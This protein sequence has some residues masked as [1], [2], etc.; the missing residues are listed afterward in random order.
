M[1]KVIQFLVILL[2]DLLLKEFLIFL[3]IKVNLLRNV[4]KKKISFLL[5]DFHV[6]DI[7]NLKMVLHFQDIVF[8]M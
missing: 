7:E 2:L 5:V 8:P 6:Y 4:Q 1:I 3:Q